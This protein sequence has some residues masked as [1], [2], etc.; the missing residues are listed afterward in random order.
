MLKL[1]VSF[2][3][4]NAMAIGQRSKASQLGCA[5]RP[6]HATANKAFIGVGGGP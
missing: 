4:I 6:V 2:R 5:R 1:L 3:G